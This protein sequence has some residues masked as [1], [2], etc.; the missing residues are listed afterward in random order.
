MLIVG[1]APT[2]RNS[3]PSKLALWMEYSFADLINHAAG[4]LNALFFG[5]EADIAQETAQISE[6][7]EP[8]LFPLPFELT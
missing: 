1:E 7:R 2:M 5:L 8:D 3:F 4:E 6:P